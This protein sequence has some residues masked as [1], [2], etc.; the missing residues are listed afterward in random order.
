[1]DKRGEQYLLK[2]DP[3]G[4]PELQ[5]G[6][7]VISTKILYAAGYNTPENYIAVFDP[8]HVR[9]GENVV[10]IGKDGNPSMTR[11]D[12]LHMLERSPK[13]PDGRYRVLASKILPGK[14]KGPFAY[15]GMRGDDPNDRVPH[16]HRRVLRGLRVIASWIDHNDLKE[17]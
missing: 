13:M 11:D 10:E 6:A 14:P 17:E 7:E 8:N 9:I 3:E 4:Y 15:M 16:E 1:K 12:L 2:F 5:S